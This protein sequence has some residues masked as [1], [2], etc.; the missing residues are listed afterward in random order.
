MAREG[1]FI[2]DTGDVL[3]GLTLETVG[4]GRVSLPEG[5]G[6]GWGV[7]LAYRAHW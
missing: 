6:D 5:F 2:L 7:F 3:P 1:S 4:H